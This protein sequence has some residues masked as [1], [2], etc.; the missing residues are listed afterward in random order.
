MVATSI[1]SIAVSGLNANATRAEVAANNVVN[2]N[3]PG[4][5]P[6]RVETTSLVADRGLDG[7]AGVQVQLLDGTDEGVNLVTE[8]TQLIASKV[9]YKASAALIRTG[10]E[11]D[12]A[13]LRSVR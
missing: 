8:F 13:L 5:R 11:L 1:F 10:T 7:G 4:F 6:T 3:T 9:A 2:Q 12:D